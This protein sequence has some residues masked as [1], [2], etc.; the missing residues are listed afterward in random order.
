MLALKQ[1][2]HNNMQTERQTLRALL[3]ADARR[4]TAW[5]FRYA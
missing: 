1:L 3:T 2:P 5:N 4:Y